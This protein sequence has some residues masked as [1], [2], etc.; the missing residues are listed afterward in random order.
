QDGATVSGDGWFNVGSDTTTLAVSGNATA[1]H[2]L[3]S[4]RLTGGGTLTTTGEASA[5]W[6][7]IDLARLVSRGALSLARDVGLAGTALET[8]GATTLALGAAVTLRDGAVWT[9][10]A[11]ATL[12]IGANAVTASGDGTQFVN[13]GV[14]RATADGGQLAVPFNNLA[15]GTLS[16]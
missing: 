5:S 14:V 3:V 12:D 13:A 6:A 10:A 8:H 16:V 2:V 11:S 7:T 9:N 15:T 4:G 1:R